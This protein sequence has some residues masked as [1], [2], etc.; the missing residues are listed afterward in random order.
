MAPA[1]ELLLTLVDADADSAGS[2]AESSTRWVRISDPARD[3]RVTLAGQSDENRHHIEVSD[4]AG[5]PVAAR[6]IGWRLDPRILAFGRWTPPTPTA[7]LGVPR[8]HRAVLASSAAG[9]GP[10][11]YI[12]KSRDFDSGFGIDGPNDFTDFLDDPPVP[13]LFPSAVPAAT[14]AITPSAMAETRTDAAGRAEMTFGDGA[15]G[16]RLVVIV[17]DAIGRTGS[18]SVDVP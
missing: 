4:V 13:R 16:G 17:V 15:L 8:G 6:V 9:A 1:V 5:L 14:G 3:L 2:A 12:P 18:L 11:A 10:Q 7:D